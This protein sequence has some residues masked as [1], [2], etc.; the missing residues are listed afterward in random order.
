MATRGGAVAVVMRARCSVM[1][2]TNVAAGARA[3]PRRERGAPPRA[4]VGMME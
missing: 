4:S 1:V 3:D 2:L